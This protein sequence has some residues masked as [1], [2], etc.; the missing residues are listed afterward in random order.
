MR[1]CFQRHELSSGTQS[2]LRLDRYLYTRR[3][4]GGLC[5]LLDDKGMKHLLNVRLECDWVLM[6]A[7]QDSYEAV[8]KAG[9]REQHLV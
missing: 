1:M 7:Y 9:S 6:E 4:A 3:T 8:S 2:A 5:D